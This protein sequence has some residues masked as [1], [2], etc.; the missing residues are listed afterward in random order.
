MPR[1]TDAGPEPATSA[2]S[3]SSDE[4]ETCATIPSDARKTLLKVIP[5]V[6]RVGEIEINTHALLDSGST[7][8]LLRA[9]V[10]HQLGA[11]GPTNPVCIQWGNGT[12]SRE[13][14]SQTVGFEVN[15]TFNG[16]PRFRLEGVKTVQHLPNYSQSIN[17]NEMSEKWPYL[18]GIPF[19]EY[20]KAQLGILIGEDNAF[21][22]APQRVVKHQWQTPIATK[23]PL[24]WTVSGKISTASVSHTSFVFHACDQVAEMEQL[25]QL[26]KRSFVMDDF[27][28]AANL[29]KGI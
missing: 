4:R 3:T 6:L 8:T 5:V 7:I 11:T 1:S 23:T 13:N 17:R 12:E 14:N 22:M 26:V 19:A 15:G 25:H 10:A 20:N 18:S 27:G 29:S 28:V 9:D 21:V 24:G 2:R 16:A